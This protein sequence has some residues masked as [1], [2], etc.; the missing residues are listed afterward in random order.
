ME[1]VYGKIPDLIKLVLQING[2]DSFLALKGIRY[3]DNQEFFRSLEATVNEILLNDI[4]SKEKA[5]LER[6]I[7]AQHQNALNF[8]LRPGHR[9]YIM[10]L[11][12]GENEKNCA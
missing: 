12:I 6:A 4:E 2:F 8:K 11:M 5:E 1:C 7:A 9:N 10:N 3:D